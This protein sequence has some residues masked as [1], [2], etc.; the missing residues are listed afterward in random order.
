MMLGYHLFLEDDEIPYGWL[1]ATCQLSGLPSTRLLLERSQ[2]AH[3]Q[4]A[5]QL[6]GYIPFISKV[7]GLSA[8]KIINEH[9]MLPLFRCFLREKTYFSVFNNLAEGS[10]SN[11]HS[12]MSLI[13]NRVSAGTVLRA[14]PEC[15]KDDLQN[16]GRA[17]WHLQHQLPG[18]S[19]CLKHCEPL[20]EVEVRRRELIQP[21]QLAPQHPLNLSDI[22]IQLSGLIDDVWQRNQPVVQYTDLLNRYR[23]RLVEAGL[24]PHIGAIRQERLRQT[25]RAYWSESASPVVQQLLLD[26][27]YPENLFRAQR[28]QF[29]PL[30]HLLLIGMLWRSWQEFVEYKTSEP[31]L[32][33]SCDANWLN[34]DNSD[35]DILRSLRGGQSLRE[36]SRY[37]KRSIKYVKKIAVHQNVQVDRRPKRIFGVDRELIVGMLKSGVKT[38]QI[39]NKVDC[40]VGAIE[41]V[42][43]QYP[44]I[45]ECRQQIRFKAKC[46]EH[47]NC[48]LSA[49]SEHPDFHRGEIQRECRASYTWLF[50][51]N[52]Q[53]LYEHVP[54]AIPRQFR[55]QGG[56]NNPKN[57]H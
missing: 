28:A 18:C 24:A 10:G 45:V 49:L 50:K 7:L 5:S 11:L 53:W 4:L 21:T 52:Q 6:P 56:K 9:T 34:E 46:L 38:R 31:G 42:L 27:S 30:K 19:V 39:A 1:A 44:D 20:V 15:I 41:Q 14:C 48:I 29:H 8:S 54:P 43:S 17:W 40:S 3:C 55:Y 12:R 13:A 33:E 26:N 51:H 37:F 57:E 16:V 36:V 47:Q 23:Q 32:H 2:L 25:L 22:D 35:A